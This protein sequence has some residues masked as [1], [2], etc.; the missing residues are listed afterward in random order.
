MATQIGRCTGHC[1]RGF[2]LDQSY[3]QLQKEFAIWKENPQNS[4]IPQIELIAPMVIPVRSS[5]QFNEYTYTC[6]NLDPAGNCMVY[7]SRPQMCRDF[8]D[9]KS[10]RFWNCTSDE[11]VYRGMNFFKKAY[12]HWRWIKSL[13]KRDQKK[14]K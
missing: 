6:K 10:C 5:S 12:S 8:P 14:K 11:S 2:A 13:N 3:A 9:K 7:E 1:C 4:T